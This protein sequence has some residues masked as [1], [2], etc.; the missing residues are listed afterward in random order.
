M[1]STPHKTDSS[2][3]GL[4]P[5]SEVPQVPTGRCNLHLLMSIALAYMSHIW[6]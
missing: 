1:S 3:L 2:M 4:Q 5:A 6:I